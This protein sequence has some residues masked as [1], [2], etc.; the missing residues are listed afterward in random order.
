MRASRRGL[1]DLRTL[2]PWQERG[3]FLAGASG[4]KKTRP[5]STWLEF[6]Q[7]ALN[8]HLPEFFKY[9]FACACEAW[10]RAFSKILPR[11]LAKLAKTA[12]EDALFQ[13]STV[14]FFA[15]FGLY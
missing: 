2:S 4:F 9:L 7:L 12:A 1:L 13:N 8:G 3:F 6:R 11:V 5:S 15:N 10:R 14:A